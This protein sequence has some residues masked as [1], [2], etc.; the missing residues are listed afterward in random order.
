MK[1]NQTSVRTKESKKFYTQN[2][3]LN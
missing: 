3:N 2:P 1:L